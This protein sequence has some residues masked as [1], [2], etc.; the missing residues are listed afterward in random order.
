MCATVADGS[1]LFGDGAAGN[2]MAWSGW[3]DAGG[4]LERVF[5]AAAPLDAP[6][7]VFNVDVSA[8][9]GQTELLSGQGASPTMEIRAS[10]DAGTTWGAWRSANLGAQGDYRARTRINRWGLFDAPGMV[11]EGRVTDPVPLRVSAF[12][13]NEAGGGR[14]R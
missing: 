11:F 3:Q 12:G 14:S 6:T 9:V 8:N 4:P 5:S 10:R 13:V 2:V 7:T 1:P